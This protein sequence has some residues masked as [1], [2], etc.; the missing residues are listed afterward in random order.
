MIVAALRAD[1][2]LSERHRHAALR[3]ELR[4]AQ[5][6]RASRATRRNRPEAK[7]KRGRDGA[8]RC[9]MA[10]LFVRPFVYSHV[11]LIVGAHWRQSSA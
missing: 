10:V 9:T 8:Y 7:D 4:R 2:A 3:A 1:R 5:P 11:L 6:P